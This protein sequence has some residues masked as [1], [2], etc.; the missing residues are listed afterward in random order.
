MPFVLQN[1]REGIASLTLARGKVNAMNREL[2]DELRE[3]LEQLATD[4][5]VKAIILTGQGK[6]FS[7]GFDIPEF[8]GRPREDFVLFLKKFTSLYAYLYLYPKAVIAAVNGH[9]VAGGCML[10]TAC[11]YRLMVTGRARISLN[12]VSFGATVF[13]GSI[14]LLRRC[15]GDRSAE[16]MLLTGAMFSAEEALEMTLVDRVVAE[17]ALAD[18]ALAA[19]QAY[20]ANYNA[21]FIEVKKLLRE[22]DLTQFGEPE[23]KS[24]ETFLKIWYSDETMKNLQQIKIHD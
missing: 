7:F 5:V 24:I 10:A 6:F 9:A 20:A 16:K 18:E 13:A 1:R 21:A 14:A 3:N 22:K 11:D 23:E 8:L 2:L 12:E 19:A 15:V 17:A 4:P